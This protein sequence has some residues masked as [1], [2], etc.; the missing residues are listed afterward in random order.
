MKNT[1]LKKLCCIFLLVVIVLPLFTNFLGIQEGFVE[2]NKG[3]KGHGTS[4]CVPDRNTI[5]TKDDKDD[6][7]G[8]QAKCHTLGEDDE[9]SNFYQLSHKKMHPCMIREE[10]S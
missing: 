2:G 3:H 7:S 8:G 10:T 1:E 5:L 4:K 9:C 6:Y